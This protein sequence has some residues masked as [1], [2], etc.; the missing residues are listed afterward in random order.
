MDI[1]NYK[2]QFER[3]IEL[4]KEDENILQVNKDISLNFKDYLISEGIG[5][6]KIGR[7]LL[8]VRKFS[9]ILNKPFDEADKSDLRHVVAE[10]EQSGLAPESKKCFK[11]MIRKL[12][13]FIREIDEKGVYPEEVRW[14]SIGIPKN[15]NKLPEEL[16]TEEEIKSII[17]NCK[18]LR[19][20]T[21]VST[22]AES[23][24]RISEVA[25]MRLK[26]VSFEEYGAR[27]TVN[28]KTGMRKILLINSTP[29]LQQWVNEHPK[30]DDL[31][32][33]LWY[34]P[35][36][37]F[38]TYHAIMKIIKQASKSAGIKKRVYAHLFR[39]SKATQMAS[40]MS[41]AS[42]KQYFGWGQDSKMCGVY[43]HM[44]GEAMDKAILKANGI[45]VKE[46]KKEKILK[47]KICLRCK[48]KNGVTN[49]C[50]YHCG[51]VLDEEFAKEKIEEDIERQRADKIMN[52]LMKDSD[53]LELIK[54]K[55]NG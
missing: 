44:S 19:D 4:L 50:C 15:Q 35:Q 8:D 38:L 42:M 29:Y 9:K 12:Y 33:C 17:R 20:K 28:G 47:E 24:C 25:T 22:L 26:H 5:V 34:N 46:E 16:L 52:D 37:D 14:I 51:L 2:R 39:H 55:L 13:R 7:Y 3:Q 1:H 43:I 21:L 6:A 32:E 48:T 53:V 23:G 10:I 36:G 45:E 30:N 31:N 40:Q 27:I 11:V 41:E 49:R 54:K 18:T